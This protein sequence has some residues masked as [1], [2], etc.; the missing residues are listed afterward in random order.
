MPDIV[1][2]EMLDKFVPR[3]TYD[4]IAK[5]YRERFAGLTRWVTFPIPENPAD[6]EL[7]AKVI[8]QLQSGT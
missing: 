6:D 8:R 4:E 2:D 1:T 5:V 3:G 7:T